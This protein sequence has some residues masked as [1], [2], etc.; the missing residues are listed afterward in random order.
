MRAWLKWMVLCALVTG[1]GSIAGCNFFGVAAT[2]VSPPELVEAKYELPDKMTLVVVD[3]PRRLV[4]NETALRQIASGTRAILEIEEVNEE[5]G[6]VGQD[7]LAAYREELGEAY[8]TT[9]LAALGLHLGARQVVHVEV[10]GFQM[11]LGGNV[12]RPAVSMNVKVFDLDE[13]TRVFPPAVD[14]DTGID[15]GETVFPVLSQLPATDTS[16]QSA[17][18]SIAIR[19]LADRAARDVARLFFD[20]RMPAPGSTLGEPQ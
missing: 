14:P 9:S 12:I 16:G 10:T 4:N 5:G 20:W 3:D 15:A 11:E 6:F 7:E 18:R 8:K 2:V 1:L 13:R 19:N 17:T